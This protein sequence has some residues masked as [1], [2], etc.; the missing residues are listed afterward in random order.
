[1]LPIKRA[2]KSRKSRSKK[3]RSFAYSRNVAN[4]KKRQARAR[5]SARKRGSSRRR[6]VWGVMVVFLFAGTIAYA[7]LLRG[8][9]GSAMDVVR[10]AG[11]DLLKRIGFG[12]EKIDI[13]G[14]SHVS[15]ED[16]IQ[17]LAI[18]EELTTLSFDTEAAQ[19]RLEELQWVKHARVMRLLP[20]SLRVD[21]TESV[22]AY[23]WQRRGRFFL[24]D[25]T[26]ETITRIPG[27]V[28]DLPLIVGEGAAAQAKELFSELSFFPEIRNKLHAAIRVGNRRWTLLLNN[29]RK[30]LLPERHIGLALKDSTTVLERLRSKSKNW[31]TVDLR[32]KDR[33]TLR[34]PIR[35]VGNR[36]QEPLDRDALERILKEI[37]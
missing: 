20:S 1:M 18:K 19:A 3:H 6:W 26:G 17:A 10:T 7:A 5:V 37:I 32:L 15:D 33:I 8:V 35:V 9:P 31:E 27:I 11:T 25:N 22:P 23:N 30:I 2:K 16:I 13:A 28:G 36:K 12:I 4:G 24:V 34:K 29:G 14:Q 21:I